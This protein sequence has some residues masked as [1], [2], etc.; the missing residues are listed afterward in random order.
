MLKTLLLFSLLAPAAHA[1]QPGISY[2]YGMEQRKRGDYAGA[3][4]TFLNMLR[5]DPG[6]GGALEGLSLTCLSLRQ[7]GEA[8]AAL[9]K[10]S[11]QSPGSAYILGLKLKA[12]NALRDDGGALLTLKE[13]AALDPRDCSVR[14]RMD[15]YAGRLDYGLFPRAKAYR[16]FSVEGLDTASP[17]RII[18]EGASASAAL[19][20]PAGRG[21]YVTG[22]AEVRREA[23]KNDG[24]GLTYYNVQEQIYS[25]GLGGRYDG[26]YAWRAEYGQSLLSDLR[27]PGSAPLSF[28][29]L[30]LRGELR[31]SSLSYSS[32][33]RLVRLPGGPRF[34]RVL[35][36]DSVRAETGRYALGWD[37]LARAGLAS[38][39]SG[40]AY[41]TASLRGV[42]DLGAG[43]LR[44]G[45]SR[46]LQEYYSASASGRFR[47]AAMDTFDAGLRR[48]VD[49]AYS[50][51]VYAAQSY[52]T[53]GNRLYA[54]GLD[55]TGWLPWQKEFSAG[56][57]FSAEDFRRSS[58]G[59]NSADGRAHW[60]GL[61]WRRCRGYNWSAGLGYEKGFLHDDS[62]GYYRGNT[63]L[64]DYQRYFGSAGS[65]RLEAKKRDTSVRDRAWSAGLE[66]RYSFR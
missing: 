54:P 16:T 49:R 26:G 48:T 12:Q 43:T 4:E 61:Y 47:A 44:A 8:L 36:E 58:S 25:A 10:W 35:R 57:R 41:G 46:G 27:S 53:D 38:Y 13:L 45:Y 15:D 23:Q 22:G 11:A 52:F 9:E 56:Y 7:Y 42:K 65:L 39:S 20:L 50:A 31:A 37:W 32:L 2:D 33:P 17:Q 59:Y 24:S 5:L 1:Q 19:R 30:N 40:S 60:L 63:Y 64:A 18:Y 34:F 51:G 14:A 28:G 62:R 55:L 29:R 21:A 66:A 6:N 3:K